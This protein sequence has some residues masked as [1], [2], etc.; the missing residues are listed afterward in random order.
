MGR[1][2]RS[3]VSIRN[4]RHFSTEIAQASAVHKDPVRFEI[5]LLSLELA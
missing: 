3:K 1:Q 2:R 5:T 4:Y